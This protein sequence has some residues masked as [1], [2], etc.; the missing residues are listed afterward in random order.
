MRLEELGEFGFIGRVARL[1]GAASPPVVVGI[2]DDAAVLKLAGDEHLLVTTDVLVEDV[3][4]R[5]QWLTAA[6]I[7]AR[8][9]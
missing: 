4:F 8:A 1:V 6:Q 3:H 7:G 5:R 2:G 9:A